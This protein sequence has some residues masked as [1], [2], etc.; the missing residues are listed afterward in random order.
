MA[1]PLDHE[2]LR[3]I[4]QSLNDGRLDDAQQ[5]LAAVDPNRAP[6][7]AV[8][9]LATRLL[10]HRGR[11]T[12]GDATE[13]VR[14]LLSTRSDF[15]EAKRFVNSLGVAPRSERPEPKPQAPVR[16]SAPRMAAPSQTLNTP[17]RGSGLSANRID[18]DEPKPPS[19]TSGNHSPPPIPKSKRP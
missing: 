19:S 16:S 10:Y 17:I 18:R 12:A 9:Y 6:T 7:D 8:A 2:S 1:G 14:E 15:P 5:G 3:A 11:L 4:E 13:R